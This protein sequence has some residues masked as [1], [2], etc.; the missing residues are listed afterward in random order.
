[1]EKKRQFDSDRTKS[2]SLSLLY[3]MSLRHRDR[4]DITQAI[5]S[6]EEGL[7]N[8][9]GRE[10]KTASERGTLA[11]CWIEYGKLL[12]R[13]NQHAKA[14]YAFEQAI[15]FTGYE[16]DALTEW[17]DLLHEQGYSDEIIAERMNRKLMQSP[18]QSEILVDILCRIGAF[19]TAYTYLDANPS[20][21]SERML[22]LHTECLIREGLFEQA[23][24]YASKA[25]DAGQLRPAFTDPLAMDTL[26]CRWILGEEDFTAVQNR[27]L[28][29]EALKRAVNLG[30]YDL[31]LSIA[32]E[33]TYLQ[34]ELTLC[35]YYEGYTKSAKVRLTDHYPMVSMDY[36]EPL[37]K[38]LAFI[39]AEIDYDEGFYDSAARIFES[40]TEK[41]P[42][43]ATY[44]FAAA[45]CY[46]KK[47]HQEME[48]R[49]SL[50]T[51]NSLDTQK[52]QHYK[53]TIIQSLYIVERSCWHTVWTP[54]QLRN[55]S[56]APT[57]RQ[58]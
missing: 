21:T 16:I 47:S 40:L 10:Y 27:Q 17:G 48:E 36:S 49:L 5:S 30:L 52:T 55:K 50:N 26:L 3:Q 44:R 35:L 53:E 6:L 19:H 37:H 4:G 31:A 43:T 28:L 57:F 13:N 9:F 8:A 22:Q 51:L 14:I 56:L 25:I 7:L 41:D 38:E 11:E 54:A 42:L 34:N 12:R 23:V 2:K 58:L 45:S 29:S 32:G 18:N 24:H 46:L 20:L 15:A 39:M 1:M 33:D